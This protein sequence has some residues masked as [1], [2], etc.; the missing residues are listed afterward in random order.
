MKKIVISEQSVRAEIERGVRRITVP[1]DAIVTALA[2]ELAATKGVSIVRGTVAIPPQDS[3]ASVP[4][5]GGGAGVTVAI[6]S[7]HGGFGLKK[8]LTEYLAT[9]GVRVVDV[10]TDSEEPCDYPDFAYL[11]A[12]SV[13]DRTVALGIMI[14]GAGIGS[15]MVVNK[16]P[17]IRGACCAHE[18]TARNAREHNNANILTLGSRVVGLEVARG[19][20]RTFVETGFAG[21]RH[22]TRVNK[23]MD[24]E[25][26]FFRM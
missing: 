24:V 8:S 14:D 18:F 25:S 13:I 11:V 2:L 6:G 1:E 19:I 9:L 5:T 3:P 21:G 7:D 23:I 15:C 20:V 10:G 26:K 22:E 16:M 12:K 4:A 17:G